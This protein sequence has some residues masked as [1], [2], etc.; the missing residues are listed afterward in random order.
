MNSEHLSALLI[1]IKLAFAT[2]LIL[3]VLAIPIAWWL[4]WSDS[5]WKPII[6]SLV[7]LPLVL[8]P[9]V[10]GFYFL[11]AFSKNSFIGKWLEQSFGISLVFSF[12]GLLLGSVIYSFPFVVR[13]LQNTFTAIGRRPME[14]A[15]I[16][17][18]SPRDAFFSVLLPLATP[19]II[20]ASILGFAHTLGEFGVVLMIGGSLPGETKVLSI[21]IFEL[22]EIG[23]FEQAHYL[24]A[25]L[26]GL[27]FI[28]LLSVHLLQNKTRGGWF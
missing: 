16:C 2:T 12:S 18:A 24:S 17:G 26:L 14:F 10:L 9:T 19:G 7:S 3:L 8:P 25:F 5:K 15:S 4:A 28:M 22:V 13:P 21:S 20:S 1:T 11:I 6:E 23:H 27:C